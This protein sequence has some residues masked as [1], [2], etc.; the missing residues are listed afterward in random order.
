MGNGNKVTPPATVEVYMSISQDKQSSFLS[1]L[2]TVQFASLNTL[3][4]LLARMFKTVL[5]NMLSK[6]CHPRRLGTILIGN[7]SEPAHR[8]HFFN[9]PLKGIH[10]I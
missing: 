4:N 6:A 10:I 7:V 2:S 1:E 9:F 3:V 5:T 8:Q